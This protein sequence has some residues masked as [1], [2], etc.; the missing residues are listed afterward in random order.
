MADFFKDAEAVDALVDAPVEA[1]KIK[2][3]DR[4]F[5]Q[6]ELNRRIGLSDIAMEA[7]EKYDRPISKFYPEF[8]KARQEADSLRAEL[9]QIKTKATPALVPGAELSPEEL[10]VQA[11]KQADELGLITKESVNNYVRNEIE[12][13]RLRD[14]INNLIDEAVADGKPKTT[15]A[16]LLNFM[17]TEGVKNPKTAYELMHR[18]ELKAWEQK[19]LDTLKKPAMVTQETSTAGSKEWENVPTTKENLKDKIGSY[20]TNQGQ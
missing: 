15:E 12:A 3:G 17:V 4:E 11:L 18:D 7:E 20:F 10:K 5:T 1:E 16:E 2:V 19:Q 9:E 13:Y 6:D 14:N 8:T